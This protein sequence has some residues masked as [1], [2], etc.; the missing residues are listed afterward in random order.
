MK[1]KAPSRGIHGFQPAV[2]FCLEEDQR[3]GSDNQAVNRVSHQSGSGEHPEEEG[4]REV[5]RHGCDRHP[6]P[7]AGVDAASLGEC[8]KL[9]EA[10]GGDGR[11]SQ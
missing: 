2:W 7:S 4:D 3:Q 5:A 8:P 11:D 9:E 1:P 10:R 6:H